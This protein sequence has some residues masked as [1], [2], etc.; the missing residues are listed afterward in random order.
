VEVGVEGSNTTRSRGMESTHTHT[1]TH[2]RAIRAA[3]KALLLATTVCWYSLNSGVVACMGHTG[4]GTQG[5]Q[6]H[7]RHWTDAETRD[8][9]PICSAAYNAVSDCG[10]LRRAKPHTCFKAVA[11]A[12]MVWLWGPPW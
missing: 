1:H 6:C 9:R 11:R 5:T 8:T 7:Q 12:E 4:E 3:A 2:P 10:V